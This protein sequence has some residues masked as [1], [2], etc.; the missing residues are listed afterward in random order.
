MPTSFSCTVAFGSAALFPVCGAGGPRLLG[1]G[2]QAGAR[3]P[4]DWRFDRHARKDPQVATTLTEAR[5]LWGS[6]EL[7]E[8]FRN[9]LRR[10]V[11]QWRLP[12]FVADCIAAREAERAEQGLTA[13]Q[14]E[15]DVK[16]S[17]GG[18][19]DIHLIRWIGF[20]HY[21]TT[22]V[23]S[24]RLNGCAQQGRRARAAGRA[25]VLDADPQRAAL[26]HGEGA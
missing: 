15:P 11:V 8:R 16:R 13:N 25:G 14:L 22:D 5:L 9:K 19:R 21:G 24:L 10:R 6:H 18:L 23:E 4:H 2:N 17:L 12:A 7:F 20:G 1:R 26:F 3:R